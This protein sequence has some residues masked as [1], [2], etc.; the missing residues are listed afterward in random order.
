MFGLE[1]DSHDGSLCICNIL[2]SKTSKILVSSVC[3]K[4]WPVEVTGLSVILTKVLCEVPLLVS[5]M[6]SYGLCNVLSDLG[7]VRVLYTFLTRF[8]NIL[9]RDLP[10]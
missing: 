9:F 10:R 8:A 6:V 1:R 5:C 7:L 2:K 4:A 3:P